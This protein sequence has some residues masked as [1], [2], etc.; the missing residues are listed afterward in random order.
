MNKLQLISRIFYLTAL[1]IVSTTLIRTEKFQLN[2]LPSFRFKEDPVTLFDTQLH[3]LRQILADQ[4]Y[5][6]YWSK[7]KI[8]KSRWTARDIKSYY[9][10]QY[11]LAPSLLVPLGHRESDKKAYSYIVGHALDNSDIE[12]VLKK[13]SKTRLVKK[14]P[15]NIFLFQAVAE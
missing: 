11:V 3:E 8:Y 7:K 15:Q 10:T 6:G 4:K 13:E 14:F 1:F 2:D 5:V 12:P 9:Y